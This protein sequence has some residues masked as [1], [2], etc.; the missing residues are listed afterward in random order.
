MDK[1]RRLYGKHEVL[2]KYLV[3]EIGYD[4]DDVMRLI[5]KGKDGISYVEIY[6]WDDPNI[7]RKIRNAI[8]MRIDFR[9]HC[10]VLG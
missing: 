10:L 1:M 4:L 6:I 2:V 8:K 5:T 9:R 7:L 3:D